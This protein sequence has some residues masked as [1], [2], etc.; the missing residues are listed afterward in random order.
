MYCFLT[1]CV[2]RETLCWV[3]VI[4]PWYSVRLACLWP[5]FNTLYNNSNNIMSMP[6]SKCFNEMPQYIWI[7]WGTGTSYFL[8]RSSV[9]V[10]SSLVITVH[11]VVALGK[12]KHHSR[13]RNSDIPVQVIP[14][15]VAEWAS[16]WFFKGH[17]SRSK[18]LKS[19]VRRK[20]GLAPVSPATFPSQNGAWGD[21]STNSVF[22][23][24]FDIYSM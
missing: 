2:F 10:S 24:S 18:S 8:K 22:V 17:D 6:H 11:Q 1:G 23:E 3:S 14:H 4:A 9:G 13:E 20:H 16:L 7:A 5:W 15:K 19:S 12:R 21:P